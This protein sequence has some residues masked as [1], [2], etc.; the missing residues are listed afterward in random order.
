MQSY[1]AVVGGKDRE[2]HNRDLSR[3]RK[4]GFGEVDSHLVGVVHQGLLRNQLRWSVN[5]N[6]DND[7]GIEKEKTT[8]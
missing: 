2:L 6:V 5:T 3:D 8:K 4:V 1:S 7:Y